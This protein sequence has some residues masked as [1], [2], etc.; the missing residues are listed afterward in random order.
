MRD[1]YLSRIY[2]IE[3]DLF[4]AMYADAP[5]TQAEVRVC[6]KR[7]ARLARK[8]KQHNRARRTL[9]MPARKS[10]TRT[11]TIDNREQIE[12]LDK[13]QLRVN[14]GQCRSGPGT[15]G[16]GWRRVVLDEPPPSTCDNDPNL[17]GKAG[18]DR[19]VRS[20]HFVVHRGK[21]YP[22]NAPLREIEYEIHIILDEP[23]PSQVGWD[24]VETTDDVLGVDVGVIRHWSVSTEDAP[25]HHAP[26]KYAKKRK[27]AQMARRIGKKPAG[28]KR[29]K[30][31]ERARQEWHRKRAADCHRYFQIAGKD[32]AQRPHKVLALESLSVNALRSS[33]KG[34]AGFPGKNVVAKR[35][36][37]RSLFD[38]AM[39]KITEILERQYAKVGKST[40]R[41]RYSGSSQCCS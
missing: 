19:V 11:V 5:V 22:A 13:Y 6:A 34:D 8:I 27:S 4:A 28:S 17:N 38:A 14:L 9:P 31:L 24:G 25:R 23:A 35:G 15:K 29:R 16:K 40:I 1:S 3:A 41:V 12:V 18:K 36:L 20:V 21:Q 37:N 26:K 10:R 32:M 33:G 30:R 39:A 2:E 7:N